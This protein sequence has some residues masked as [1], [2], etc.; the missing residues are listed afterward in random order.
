M[1]FRCCIC[2]MFCVKIKGTIDYEFNLKLVFFL[3]LDI[4]LRLCIKFLLNI[5]AR[6]HR[7]HRRGRTISCI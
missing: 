5:I 3:P 1:K 4:P 2:F 7:D 6:D